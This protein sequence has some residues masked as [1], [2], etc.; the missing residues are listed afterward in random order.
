[1]TRIQGGAMPFWGNWLRRKVDP[2]RGLAKLEADFNALYESRKYA[3]A[4][5][6]AKEALATA[7]EQLGPQDVLVAKW[8]QFLGQAYEAAGGYEISAAMEYLKAADIYRLYTGQQDPARATALQRL[9]VLYRGLGRMTDAQRALTEAL[10]VQRALYGQDHPEVT[11]CKEYCD[12]LSNEQVEMPL[13]P[14]FE[15]SSNGLVIGNGFMP[16]LPF[17][18]TTGTFELNKELR[19]LTEEA[20]R[21]REKGEFEHALSLTFTAVRLA[22]Q[23]LAAGE[24]HPEYASMLNSLAR[25][26]FVMGN[27]AKAEPLCEEARDIHK[28]AL[29]QWAETLNLWHT[30]LDES[31][32]D[33]SAPTHRGCRGARDAAA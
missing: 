25:L 30:V 6:L 9:G 14:I 16:D 2:I 28:R 12:R 21:P 33:R 11:K 29:Q 4:R 15:P 8:H 5:K 32:L 1:M 24:V 26:Y 22:R 7:R 19:Q 20:Y 3:D 17:Q 10:E 13:E 23:R 31:L 18:I 27:Y